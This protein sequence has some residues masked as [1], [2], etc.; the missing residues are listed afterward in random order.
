MFKRRRIYY[1]NVDEMRNLLKYA[2]DYKYIIFGEPEYPLTFYAY[3]EDTKCFIKLTM[4]YGEKAGTW[5]FRKDLID[6][7]EEITGLDAYIELSKDYKRAT[8]EKIPLIDYDVG[9]ARAILSYNTE[10][11]NK[12]V[13]AWCYDQNSA[14]AI[15]MLQDMPNT[16]EMIGTNRNVKDGE[17]GF[18]N[19]EMKK[20]PKWVY[21]DEPCLQMVLPGEGIASYIFPS[22]ESPFKSFSQRWFVRKQE[23]TT[24]EAK[25]K[26]KQMLVYSVGYLQRKNPFLRAAVVEYANRSI[27]KVIDLDTTIYCNTDSIV[28]V[29]KRDDLPIGDYLGQFK[30]EHEGLFAHKGFNYQWNY[31][32]PSYRG[33]PNA[34]FCDGW[35][36]LKDDIPGNNNIYELDQT[37]L[38]IY[39]YRE[40]LKNEI[41]TKKSV[42]VV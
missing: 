29:C 26:A 4:R 18:I 32:K 14:Y 19:I 15:A 39:D 22:M 27:R 33:I 8:G 16:H 5:V 38:E 40:A 20:T 10:Y 34:W 37:T 28:S 23:A 17:I 1:V 24:S 35:D 41:E 30:V 9:S 6:C 42:F 7:Q 12:R 2:C 13:Q 11:N 21:N 36:I 3:I 31:D 25:H